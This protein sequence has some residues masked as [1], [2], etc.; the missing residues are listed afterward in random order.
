MNK[1]SLDTLQ[2][3]LDS[4]VKQICV[5]TKSNLELEASFGSYK[6]PIS[7]KKFHNLLKYIKVK[8][9]NNKLKTESLTTLDILYNYDQKTNSTYRL[10]ISNNNDINNFIQNNSMLKNNTIFSK[11]IRMYI[12]QDK[13]NNNILLINK[14]KSTDKFIALDE[15]NI[16]IKVSEEN[17]NIEQSILKNLLTL[18]ESERHH[19][20]YRYKQRISLIVHDDSDYTMRIDLTDVK[21]TKNVTNINNSISQYELEVD[22]SFKKS[23]KDN[24]LS[25]ILNLFGSTIINL[26]Q[27]LQES[28]LLITKTESTNVIKNL[29]KLAYPDDNDSYNDLPAMQ[30]ASLEIQHLLD[31][32][33]GNYTVS[34]KADG[35][36]SFL[37]LFDNQAY[38]IS[39]NL[40]VKK[41]KVINKNSAYNLTVLD[42]E[43]MY[44]PRYK[45]FLF[46]TFDIL[47]FQ[48]KDIRTEELF[49]NRLL[50]AAKVLK[51]VF[52]LDMS[53][54]IYKDTNFDTNEI[55]NYHKLNIENHLVQLNNSLSTASDNQVINYKYF[56]FPI[57][58]SDNLIYK[59]STLMY[60]IYT[61]STKSK[62]PYI[63]DGMIYTPINQIYTRVAKDIKNKIYKWKPAEHNSVDFYIKF[64]RNPETNKILTV[65]DRTNENGLE[66]YVD[67]IKTSKVIDYNEITDYKVNN[68]VYQIIN[69]YVGKVKNNLETP[70]PFQKENDLNV[71][72]IYLKNGY[73]LDINGNIIEDSTVVEFSYNDKLD[74]DDKFRWIPLRTRFD[75]TES[76]MRN[77]RKYG[78]NIDIA[79]KVWNSIKNPITYNDIKLLGDKDT[80][81]NQIKNLKSKITSEIITI[82]R[83]DDSY[84]QLIT[85]IGKP[86]RNFHN[87]IKSNMIYTY[88]SQ[89]I[90][91]DR[92]IV[93]MDVLDIGVGKGGDIMKFYHAG[94]KSVV[95]TDVNESS[96]FSGSDGAM[97]RYNAVKKKMP[98]FP[99]M[100]F[101]IADG[102]QKFDYTNQATMGKMNEENI[103]L[104]KQVFGS[105]EKTNK[106]FTFDIIN[107]QFMIHY[108][109]KNHITWSNFCSNVNKYLRS[110]GYLLI[111]TLDGILV[112]KEF[113]DDH[114]TRSYIS[115]DGENKILFDIVKKYNS[116]DDGDIGVQID[117]H[118]P[119]FMAEG[120]Y[121]SEYLVK[122]S[123]FINELKTKCNMRLVE[124]ESFQNLYYVYQNFF[125]HTAN[126]E[127]ELRTRK[128]FNDVKKFYDKK[129]DI[130]KDWFEYSKL[131]RYY[132]FQKI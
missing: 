46:L 9:L 107:A 51:D 106:H 3:G 33:P 105:D 123:F 2:F 43:Y 85:N 53:I 76:V 75:K 91:L 54:G 63:L 112:D 130:T 111:T 68:T 119:M 108:L 39:N 100:F 88:C 131:N 114:I 126:Y 113:K 56:M 41:I 14:I 128:F 18:D 69:L 84:Y 89:K 22:I 77:R 98:N 70:F 12:N 83:R 62:C 104:L 93:S 117:V 42:G 102:C 16:R 38:L 44:V 10:T 101:I 50:L 30:S 64:E 120:V 57:I 37:M 25:E 74:I 7:L 35:E 124:T 97:S 71:C 95:A 45:K 59:L 6:K 86:L 87:W 61:T 36:R 99:K 121:Q 115:P 127:S 60:D 47:F 90:L 125:E 92:S 20:I 32:V 66:D 8:S 58:G 23:I 21:T 94:A 72:Y 109:L 40:E 110:D 26:E 96:I 55:Y 73:P 52:N 82:T 29:N 116:V 5:N 1:L 67:S 81:Q 78:N 31:Y 24:K 49:K 34:D 103:K 65:Y 118:L 28:A 15:Y 4:K 27:F 79:N 129:D 11:Q 48:G 17:T 80:S 13:T 19:V 122:P 132:I